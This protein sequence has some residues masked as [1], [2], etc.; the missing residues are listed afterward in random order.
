MSIELIFETHAIT[1]DNENGIAT[2]WLPGTLS[3]RG[4]ETATD[5]GRRRRRDAIAAVHVSDLKRAIDTARIA[6][7]D[8]DVPMFP[9]ARLRECNYGNLNGMPKARLDAERAAH[10]AE[11]WPG[12]ESY[13][14]VVDRT[15]RLVLDLVNAWDGSR[16]LLIGHSANKWALDHLLVGKDLSE[17]VTAG[18]EWQAGWEYLVPTGWTTLPR[19]T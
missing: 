3:K 8:S 10:I 5:L 16:V 6:F 11:P 17:L 2:G 19:S 18:I 14:D 13:Q 1:T 15:R 9:D 4:R 7:E 12:G